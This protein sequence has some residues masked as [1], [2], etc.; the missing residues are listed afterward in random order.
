MTAPPEPTDDLQRL[1]RDLAEAIE[2][3]AATS[4]VLEVIGSLGFELEPVFE[5]VVQPRRPAVRRRLRDRSTSSTATS[6]GST[7]CSAARPSTGGYWRSTRSPRIRARWSGG[8]ARAAHRADR[9]RPLRPRY[10]WHEAL[11]L[12]GCRTML[13]VPM[14]IAGQVDRRDR[15]S[16]RHAGRP[17]RRS[18]DRAGDDLRA[19]GAIAIQNVQLFKQLRGPQRRAGALGRR[20]ARRWARSARR[21]ARASTSSEVLTTIVTRAVEL[22]GTDGGSIFEFDAR[23]PGVPVRHVLRH[24]ATSWSRR[25]ARRG[26]TSTRRSSAAPPRAGEPRQAPDLD[27]G[28]VATPTSTRSARHGWRSMLAVPLLREDEII[29]ALVV[30]RQVPGAFSE[31]DRRPA[32]DASRASRRWRSTTRACSASSR[33]RRRQ[34]EV[35]SRAQVRVPGQ[36]VARA[37]HAAERRDR[38]LGRAA[39]ADVRRAERA[40]GRVPPGHPRLR[41]PPARADQRDPRPV[42]GRGGPDG[43]RARRRSRCRTCSSTGWRWCASAPRS[44]GIVAR[45]STLD[46]DVGIV[47]PTSSSSSR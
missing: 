23:R 3:Q 42:E 7:C 16:A 14:L 32:R 18:H 36:H 44:H 28:A 37:A 21:S 39:R 8:S 27:A 41:A 1:A 11:A 10:Q 17:V 12:G 38:L 13:G 22:S 35:A 15:R 43:A 25:C 47:W 2:Q 19:Q 29:G 33:R 24:R 6:T 46:P 30:R 20:A 45:G 26:S 4:E 31:R 5:T 34:L 40:P 9:G